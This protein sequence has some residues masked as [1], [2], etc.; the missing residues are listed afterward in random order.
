MN[1]NDDNNDNGDRKLYD[2]KFLGEL[3][4]AMLELEIATARHHL[5]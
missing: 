1:N 5:F 4:L 3:T 2:F